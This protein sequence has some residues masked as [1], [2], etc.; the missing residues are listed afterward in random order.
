[1]YIYI[2]PPGGEDKS[3]ERIFRGGL[4]GVCVWKGGGKGGRELGIDL[5]KKLGNMGKAP[6][7]PPAS[8]ERKIGGFFFLGMGM[9]WNGECGFVFLVEEG[10]GDYIDI[11]WERVE[12]E[13]GGGGRANKYFS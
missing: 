1:M 5:R 12:I 9:G 8:P 10:G 3:Q 11:V 2:L 7:P 4:C 6:V 13:N